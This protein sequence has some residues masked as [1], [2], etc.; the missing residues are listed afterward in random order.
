MARTG[1]GH[2][3][4]SRPTCE[5][6]QTLVGAIVRLTDEPAWLI[7]ALTEAI[8]AM[9]PPGTP[10]EAEARYLLASGAFTSEE[11]T[12]ISREVAR[13]SLIL[14]GAEALLTGIRA[15]WSVAQTASYLRTSES[16]VVD[17]AR[18][19]RLYAV[20]LSNRLRFPTCRFS[21]GRP[22]P[23][24]PHFEGLVAAIRDRWHWLSVVS[25]MQTPQEDHI[26]VARQTPT[27][28]LVDGGSVDAVVTIIQTTNGVDPPAAVEVKEHS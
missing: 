2:G 17:D 12:K 16:A 26:A 11:L 19:G 9:E 27:A 21:I 22:E 5:D 1:R 10:S 3:D 6:V 7:S 28:W 8:A 15:T 4:G 25:F 24:I 18:H 13:G 23:L 14:N 20:E